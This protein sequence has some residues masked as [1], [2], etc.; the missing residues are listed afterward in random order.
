MFGNELYRLGR[1]TQFSDYALGWGER[2][3]DG[4]YD[5]FPHS[6]GWKV[7]EIDVTSC[8]VTT[9]LRGLPRGMQ[10]GDDSSSVAESAAANPMYFSV[11]LDADLADLAVTVGARA[12]R[13]PEVIPEKAEALTFLAS[14]FPEGLTEPPADPNLLQH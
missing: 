14:T 1:I 6:T 3:D 2:T 8:L 11:V 4:S 9:W 12:S 13:S 10:G 7:A 5:P